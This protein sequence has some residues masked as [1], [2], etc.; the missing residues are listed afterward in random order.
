L[1]VVAAARSGSNLIASRIA[2]GA[3]QG[4]LASSGGATTER[5]IASRPS[6]SRIQ[7]DSSPRARARGGAAVARRAGRRPART[8]G[9][10]SR[11]RR[12]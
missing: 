2:A 7:P 3:S 8:S 12:R 1:G 5:R 10:A 4:R 6:S 9:T 11:P